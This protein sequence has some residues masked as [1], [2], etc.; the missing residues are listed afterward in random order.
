MLA[1]LSVDMIIDALAVRV[2]GLRAARTHL[3]MDWKLTDEDRVVR[4]TLSNGALTHRQETPRAPLR[5]DVDLTLTLSKPQLLGVLSGGGLDGVYIDG[6]PA[7][8][9]RLIEVLDRPDPR[10]PIVTP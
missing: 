9:A 10:F 8:L 5:G 4:L 7:L 6:D 1:A 3:T 2:D